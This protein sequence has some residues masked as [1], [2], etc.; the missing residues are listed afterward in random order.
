MKKANKLFSILFSLIIILFVISCK[1]NKADLKLNLEKGIKYYYSFVNNQDITQEMMGDTVKFVQSITWGYQLEVTEVKEGVMTIKTTYDHI[2]MSNDNQVYNLSYDSKEPL[3]STNIFAFVM[4]NFIDKSF[5]MDVSS[6]GTVSNIVG[7]DDIFTSILAELGE[8]GEII[9]QNLRSQ[10][11]EET[12][13]EN[14]ELGFKIFPKEVVKIGDTWN[15]MNIVNGPFSMDIDNTYTLKS[16]KSGVATVE[17]TST[18]K[19]DDEITGI[20]DLPG[21]EI[22]IDGSQKG[23]LQIE[24]KTGLVIKSTINQEINQLIKAQGM[25]IPVYVKSDLEITSKK[26]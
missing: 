5:T 12:V 20:A 9:I 26:L 14:L 21:A 1:E 18:I 4:S 17:L 2:K 8:D 16:I 24:I 22:S 7:F 25:E 3:D 10:F 13:S 6:D 19:Q 11:S 15:I 23:E